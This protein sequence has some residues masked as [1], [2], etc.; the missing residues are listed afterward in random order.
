MDANK[1]PR[2]RTGAWEN[3]RGRKGQS[4]IG[5]TKNTKTTWQRRAEPLNSVSGAPAMPCR[6]A[7][8]C[9]LAKLVVKDF[10]LSEIRLDLSGRKVKRLQFCCDERGTAIQGVLGGVLS[11]TAGVQ[12]SRKDLILRLG[13]DLGL[14]TCTDG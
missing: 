6:R 1:R 4:E 12:A 3:G 9:F 5:R 8:A 7:F 13:K 10:F 14:G 11:E 2:A